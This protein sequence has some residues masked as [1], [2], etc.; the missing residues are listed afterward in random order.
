MN[1]VL[2]EL[3]VWDIEMRRLNPNLEPLTIIT[4]II[5][6]DNSEIVVIE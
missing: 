4:N 6:N 5:S 1:K 3:C 2:D